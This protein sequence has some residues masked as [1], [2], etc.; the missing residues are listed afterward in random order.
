VSDQTEQALKSGV[1]TESKTTSVTTTRR[2]PRLLIALACVVL[3]LA[4]AL[5]MLAFPLVL[6]AALLFILRHWDER[7]R[8]AVE[9]N[10]HC[11]FRHVALFRNRPAIVVAALALGWCRQRLGSFSL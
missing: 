9:T 2:V 7:S 11:I 8:N 1:S 5:S 10:D 6:A 3:A 4:F